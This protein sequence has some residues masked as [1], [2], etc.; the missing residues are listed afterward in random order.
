MALESKPVFIL[1]PDETYWRGPGF[2]P[3]YYPE[4]LKEKGVK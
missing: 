2:V 3:Y 4:E 1:H